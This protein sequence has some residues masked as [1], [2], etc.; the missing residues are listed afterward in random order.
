MSSPTQPIRLAFPVARV[1]PAAN[2]VRD[3]C[4]SCVAI[5]AGLAGRAWDALA[6]DTLEK[7]ADNLALLTPAAFAYYLPAFMCGAVAYPKIP[8]V[9][10]SHLLDFTVQSLCDPELPDDEWWRERAELLSEKQRGAIASFLEWAVNLLAPEEDEQRLRN[11]AKQALEKYWG[12][13]L[14]ARSGQ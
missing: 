12:R 6:Q 9:G 7:Q 13:Y 14:D 11:Q 5:R 8:G 2:L 4:S 1:P 10:A 3:G